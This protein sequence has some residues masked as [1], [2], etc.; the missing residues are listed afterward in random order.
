MLIVSID[1]VGVPQV[2]A[3]RGTAR[4]AGGSRLDVQVGSPVVGTTRGLHRLVTFLD[5]VVAIAITLLVLPLVEAAG[6]NDVPRS[7]GALLDAHAYQIGAFGL[8]FAVVARLWLVHHGL[9]EHASAC[10]RRVV[11]LN[12]LWAA[13]IVLLPFVTQLV[14]RFGDDRGA[15]TAYIGCMASS[16]FLLTVMT[17]HLARRPKLLREGARP[18]PVRATGTT[19][20]FVVALVLGVAGLGY[21]PLLLLAVDGRLTELVRR[22]A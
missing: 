16:S 14:A 20:A 13:T 21:W 22:W 6:E 19:A 12:L 3:V 15:V 9:F 10:D 1:T 7:V 2:Y 18:D 4:C 5:A 17:W 11:L 8:S